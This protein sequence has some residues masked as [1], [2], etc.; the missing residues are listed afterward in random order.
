MEEETGV[1]ETRQMYKLTLGAMAL[2]VIGL[3][4]LMLDDSRQPLPNTQNI[5]ASRSN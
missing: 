5:M 2:V 1:G 3:G 4:L